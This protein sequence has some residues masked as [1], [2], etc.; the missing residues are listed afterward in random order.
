MCALPTVTPLT[1]QDLILNE[2]SGQIA[3]IIV[4]HTVELVVKAWDNSSINPDDVINDT[5]SAFHHPMFADGRSTLQGK[6]IQHVQNWIGTHQDRDYIL[7]ALTKESVRAGKNK[8]KG[9]GTTQ[10]ASILPGPQQLFNSVTSGIQG[11]MHGAAQHI[12]GYQQYSSMMGQ[13]G[14]RELD[15]NEMPAAQP[16]VPDQGGYGQQP[17]Y[18][19]PQHGYG[20]EPQYPQQG[21]ACSVDPA[22]C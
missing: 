4:R 8:R 22:S 2:C 6:M 21:C 3:R 10:S 16:Y 17:S 12:P 11:Q 5:L 20:N 19:A 7:R 15:P 13:G 14:R 1:L 9:H 18:S